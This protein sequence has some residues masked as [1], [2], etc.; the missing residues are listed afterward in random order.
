MVWMH[1][2][3]Q[4]HQ[5]QPHRFEVPFNIW[6]GKCGEHIAKGVRFNAEKKQVRVTAAG[7][8]KPAF[9]LKRRA[10]LAMRSPA[11]LVPS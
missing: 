3:R 2:Q 8:R 4:P 11:P 9:P 5:R 1:T 10:R 6:C 7:W